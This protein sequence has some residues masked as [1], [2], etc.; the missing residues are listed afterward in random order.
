MSRRPWERRDDGWTPD[1]VPVTK[2]WWGRARYFTHCKTCGAELELG[3]TVRVQEG[4]FGRITVCWECG[5][6]EEKFGGTTRPTAYPRGYR[7]A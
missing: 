6:E 2:A 5:A 7:R 4:D 3:Q 1:R